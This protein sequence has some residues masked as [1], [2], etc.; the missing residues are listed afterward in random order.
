MYYIRTL[1]QQLADVSAQLAKEDNLT[2]LVT[3]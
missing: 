1:W 2:D 3:Q